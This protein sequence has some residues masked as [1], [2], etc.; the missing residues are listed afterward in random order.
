VCLSVRL[1][2]RRRFRVWMD[3]R[4]RPG[5]SDSENGIRPGQSDSGIRK[6]ARPGKN[7][8]LWRGRHSGRSGPGWFSLWGSGRPNCVCVRAS[9]RRR[10]G[11]VF[12]GGTGHRDHDHRLPAPR[13][14]GGG[15][16][17]RAVFFFFFRFFLGPPSFSWGWLEW[18]NHGLPTLVISN[19]KR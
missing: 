1:S 17:D 3:R 4:N 10:S 13:G 8:A 11:S 9:V 16:K 12:C 14:G 19:P 2:V 18:R 5:Q 15:G 6:R 7:G